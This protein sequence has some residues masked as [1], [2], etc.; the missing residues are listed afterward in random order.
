MQNIKLT[1]EYDGTRFQGWQSQNKGQRTVQD[2]IEGALKKICKEKIRLIGSGRTD[3]GVHALAQVANFKTKSKRPAKEY[4]NALNG[5]LPKDI[6][7][8]NAESVPLSFHAQYTAKKKTYRYSILY[9]PTRSALQHRFSFH[10]ST[11]L[12]VA[13]MRKE[14]KT[15]I[16]RKDFASFQTSDPVRK[17]AGKQENTI[18]HITALNIK[19]H[20][21]VIAIDITANGFLYKMVRN[22][23][24][25]LLEIG[26]GKKPK[27]SM[28]T[29]L[30]NK[31]RT[32]AG[33]TAKACGLMLLKVIY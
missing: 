24:G 15:L 9:R 21:D 27:G 14:A 33:Q 18:R 7:I 17:R 19:K 6:S 4:I 31:N 11:Q 25:T 30:K 16:G 1:I 22:I 20:G 12:N 5:N 28:Q 26:S 10:I 23:V 32:M 8:I 29:I 2:E 13:L 3:S